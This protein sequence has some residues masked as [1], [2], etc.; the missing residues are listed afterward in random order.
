MTI[1]FA[2][3]AAFM[4]VL[5]PLANSIGLIDH[6]GGRKA[7]VGNVPIIGGVAMFFGVFVGLTL[8]QGPSAELFS[9]FV[10]CLML[11][12]I[13]AL[14]DRFGLP[15]T[16]RFTTQ[17]AAA[18]I[19]VYG[20]G[21]QLHDIGDPFGIGVL[22]LNGFSLIATVIV[23]VTVINAYN[24]VDGVDGLAGSLALIGLFAVA[25]A[26][27][28]GASSTAVALMIATA[29]VGFLVFNFPMNGNRRLRSFMGDAGSTFLGFAIVW[30]A[31]SVSQGSDGIISPVYCLWFAA[32]PIFDC[33]T[34]FVRRLR[35]HKSPLTPG[36]DHF[37]HVLVRSGMRARQVLAVLV[38]LQ[39][40]YAVTALAGHYAGVPDFV[41]FAAW[42]VLG[43]TQRRVIN[44]V[45][46]WYHHLP[47]QRKRLASAD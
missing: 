30:V 46:S 15:T 41:M 29:I 23:T 25:I 22:S 39:L 36:R 3:T 6:P 21:L 47:S 44:K 17:I 43:L 4:F 33:M 11:V 13:G 5:R 42:A 7:H 1:A 31:L 37:H 12:A 40:L 10:A 8:I 16:V 9:L 20:G 32:I 45:A 38:G 28:V 14:D 19:M 27:G 35:R 18:L 26:G 34:C 24:F 2:V